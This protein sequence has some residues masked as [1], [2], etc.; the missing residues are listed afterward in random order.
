[1]RT[2]QKNEENKMPQSATAKVA[3]W[4]VGVI[5][6]L[7]FCY[8][9]AHYF[10]P[11]S[12]DT[13]GAEIMPP[14]T[15]EATSSHALPQRLRIPS[16]GIDTTIE[17]VGINKNGNMKVPSTYQTVAW[18]NKGTVPGQ[19]G[20]AVIIGHL[21]NGLGLDAVFA[22]LKDLKPNDRIVVQDAD[23]IEHSFVVTKLE[24]Y[25]YDAAP[26]NQIFLGENGQRELNLITC[27]GSWIP[28]EH[29]YSDR[30]VVYTKAV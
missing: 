26:L 3:L 18:Y 7:F 13:I 14:T 23:N 17:S 19:I 6:T 4:C 24:T 1:M 8:L 20:A 30:L 27:S 25:A 16:L 5:A 22:H 28:N 29:N 21:D 9:V 2:P 10:L 12:V 11:F 15:S